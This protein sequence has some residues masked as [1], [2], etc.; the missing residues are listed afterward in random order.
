[1]DFGLFYWIYTV[2]GKENRTVVGFTLQLSMQ[3]VPI[4]TNVVSFNHAHGEV[5][6]MQHYVIK[7]VTDLE[8]VDSFL[9]VL[10]FPP[11]IKVTAMRISFSYYFQLKHLLI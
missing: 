2:K 4:T 10:L 9:R 1:V 8:Q 3:L 6:S 5:Y 7:F 11:Q